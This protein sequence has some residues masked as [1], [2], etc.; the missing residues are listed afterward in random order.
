MYICG[1]VKVGCNDE[2]S[3]ILIC[4]ERNLNP[5]E[6]HVCAMCIVHSAFMQKRILFQH[7]N[8]RNHNL[9]CNHTSAFLPTIIAKPS[10]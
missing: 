5:K 2:L 3:L 10:C 9:I 1:K 6:Y 7:L 8:P 4:Y